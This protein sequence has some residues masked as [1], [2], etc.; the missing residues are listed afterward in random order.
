TAL[1]E[2]RVPSPVIDAEEV[3]PLPSSRKRLACGSSSAMSPSA[4]L[5]V[6]VCSRGG[7]VG[8]RKRV[9]FAEVESVSTFVPDDVR[10]SRQ[11]RPRR[12]CLR[13]SVKEGNLFPVDEK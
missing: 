1:S 2:L 4:P 6:S 11:S 12:S 9:T 5:G 3:Q 8:P 10:R 13:S 7:D